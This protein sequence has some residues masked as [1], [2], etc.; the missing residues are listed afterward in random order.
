MAR[1]NPHIIFK[2]NCEA[3]F[4]FYQSIFGGEFS[5]LGRFKDMPTDGA[6]KC[7]PE[8]LN[9]IMHIALPIS[10]ETVISGSDSYESFGMKTVFGTN[11]TLSISADSIEE[12]DQIFNSLSHEGTVVMP[13]SDTFWGGY[14]GNLTDKFGISWMINFDKNQVT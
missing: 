11:F 6:P 10:K 13:M 5:Y 2:E 3:A 7:R 4:L 8:D 1:I 14:F 12:A 9:K